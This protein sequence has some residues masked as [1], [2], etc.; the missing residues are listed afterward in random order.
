MAGD[1]AGL[2]H[3]YDSHLA[4][5]I[6]DRNRATFRRVAVRIELATIGTRLLGSALSGVQPDHV[7]PRAYRLAG[8]I[9]GRV[10]G[11][12]DA[13]FLRFAIRAGEIIFAVGV[14]DATLGVVEKFSGLNAAVIVQVDFFCPV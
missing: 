7:I 11:F 6:V 10:N 13:G 2:I 1:G 9:A 8:F 14:N 5:G 12:K 3:R 4:S